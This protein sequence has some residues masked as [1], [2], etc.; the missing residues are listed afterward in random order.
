[1]NYPNFKPKLGNLTK[2]VQDDYIQT[3]INYNLLSEDDKHNNK[4]TSLIASNDLNDP[5]YFWQI[6]SVLGESPIHTVIRI[7][8]EN[9]FNDD[10]HPWFRDTF[11]KLGSVDYHVMGQK[12]FWLDV[13]GGGKKYHGGLSKLKFKHKM[14]RKI[15]TERGGKLWIYHIQKALNDPRVYLTNDR[16]ILSCISNFIDYFMKRYSIEFDFNFV[17]HDKITSNL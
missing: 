3:M 11:A 7:F 1:M 10:D 17:Y 12:N 16:R 4:I 9:I 8:Y 6:Y 2:S 15:M 14:S 13:M 5:I